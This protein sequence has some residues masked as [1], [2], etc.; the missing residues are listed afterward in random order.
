M[1]NDILFNN[2]FIFIFIC[3]IFVLCFFFLTLSIIMSQPN[4]VSE[5]TDYSKII[6]NNI[7]IQVCVKREHG[8]C[9]AKINIT[10]KQ[11]L[12]QYI[13]D[14]YD[15]DIIKDIED[16]KQSY[17]KYAWVYNAYSHQYGTRYS[18]LKQD[19]AY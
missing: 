4:S 19:L 3:W 6:D 5:F 18:Y 9:V 13:N 15:T 11:E 7:P 10:N 2:K 1:K 16:F 14:K 8:D 17:E 12:I